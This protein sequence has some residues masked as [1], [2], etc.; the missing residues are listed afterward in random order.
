MTS[1]EQRH[2][3]AGA[4][5]GELTA[6]ESQLLLAK[7]RRQPELLDELSRLTVIERL[8][9]Y[10]HVYSDDAIFVREVR[11]RLRQAQ[12]PPEK[13]IW[14]LPWWQPVWKWATPAAAV[15]LLWGSLAAIRWLKNGPETRVRIVRTE[16]V[17]TAPGQPVLQTGRELPARRLQLV[18]G[19][20]ELQFQSGASVILE[21]PADFEVASALRCVL[22]RGKVVARVPEA[23]HGFTVEGPRGRLVDLGTEFGVTVRPSGDTEVHVLDGRVQAIPNGPQ[24]PL[25]L[26]VN[27]AL[28]LTSQK[29]EALPVDTTAFVTDMP[30]GIN[31]P[32]G[33]V[34]W[35]FDEGRGNISRNTGQGLAH[36]KAPAH[37]LSFEQQG[38]GPE[39]VPGQFGQGLSLNGN[40]DYVECDFVGIGGGQPRTV[41][42]W[43]KVPQ[44]MKLDQ[45]DA[46]INWGTDARLGAV[47]RVS[48]N[49]N[50]DPNPEKWGGPLGRLR[51]G[52]HGGYVVGTTDLRDDRWHHCAVVM[53]GGKRPNLGSHVLIYIDGQLEPAARKKVFEIS[54]DVQHATAHNIWIGRNLSYREAGQ[55]VLGGSPFFRG[56]VDEVFVFNAALPQEQIISLMKYNHLEAL[57]PIVA[58]RNPR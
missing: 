49:N 38:P 42:F 14:A 53:Y 23:A 8:L 9:S 10:V 46:I 58:N 56:C 26:K 20:L 29:T 36:E 5:A 27:Q 33:Y 7:C 25:E 19:L 17:S 35:A 48:I 11:E 30:P 24:K 21:G 13:I 16:A 12:A 4:L 47:W 41:A 2:W 3:V 18:S 37:R 57:P 55:K 43:V 39:W 50:P 32:I 6:E 31:G 15:L 22:H 44:D 40:G 51:V 52:V 1:E 45:S 28:R 54:T 34:H